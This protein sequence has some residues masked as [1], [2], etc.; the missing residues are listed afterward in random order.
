[1]IISGERGGSR[2]SWMVCES[3]EAIRWTRRAVSD[4]TEVRLGS[5]VRLDRHWVGCEGLRGFA[6]VLQAVINFQ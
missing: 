1:M 5:Y 6:G 3:G 4:D 2:R